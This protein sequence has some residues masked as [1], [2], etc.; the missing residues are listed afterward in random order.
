MAKTN[1]AETGILVT[2]KTI[3]EQ[4]GGRIDYEKDCWY[5]P[6]KSLDV[7]DIFKVNSSSNN[8]R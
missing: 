2:D 3:Q 6:A 8:I 7:S 5:I 1:M 4:L